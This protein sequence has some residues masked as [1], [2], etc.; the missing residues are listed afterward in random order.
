MYQEL[1][2]QLMMISIFAVANNI[3]SLGNYLQLTENLTV[4]D[5]LKAARSSSIASF[6]SMI[7]ALV[8]GD[9]VLRF[10]GVSLNAFQI[11][12]GIILLL[13]GIDMVNLRNRQPED[14]VHKP[15]NYSTIISTAIIPIAI[16]LTTGAGTFSTIIIF[17][18]KIG[19]NYS[20]YWQ[21][22]MAIVLQAL[23]NYLIF[24]YSNYLLKILG[25]VGMGILIRI[26]GLFTLTLGVQFIC[27]GLKA[28]FI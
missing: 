2:F 22:V 12:G 21:L 9:Y 27:Y 10:F 15:L 28:I 8:L 1:N 23:L 14:I 5:K 7:V 19:N 24:R 16:P 26:V 4:L 20:L 17:A 6:F 11:A 13:I 25:H 18:A 3:K